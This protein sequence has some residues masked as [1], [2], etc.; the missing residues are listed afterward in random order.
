MKALQQIKLLVKDFRNLSDDFLESRVR[1]STIKKNSRYSDLKKVRISVRGGTFS[2][3]IKLQTPHQLGV[4]GNTAFVSVINP[5]VD[6]VINKPNSCLPLRRETEKNWLLHIEPPGYIQK[7]EMNRLKLV[8]KFGRVYTSDPKLYEQGG[9]FIASPP[10]VHWHLAISSY[11]QNLGS[12][13]YDFDFL[14]SISKPPVKEV[15]LVTINSS[16]ND[17]PGHKLRADFISMISNNH[18]DFSLYGSK[19][20]SIY[21]QYKG[22]APEG[23]WPIYSK[24]KYVLVIENEISDFYWTEKFTDAILCYSMPIYYGC[25]KIKNYFPEGSYVPLDI[26]KPSAQDDLRAILES[27]FYER[28]LPKLIEA[29][30]LILHKLNLFNFIDSEI[31]KGI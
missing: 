28:N 15:S 14:E 6:L 30:N 1:I 12:K 13:V 31:N 22:T 20:W 3:F 18:L 11:N 7:L 25:P 23:K 21:K 4:L 29:R 10:Y 8:E 16:I 9:K 2:Q 5:D 24:S 27:D 17:L 26:T 19:K